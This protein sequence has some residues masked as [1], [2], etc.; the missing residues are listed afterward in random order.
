MNSTAETQAKESAETTAAAVAPALAPVPPAPAPAPEP[1]GGDG[2]GRVP[3]CLQGRI[4]RAMSSITNNKRKSNHDDAVTE[5]CQ[6]IIAED[7]APFHGRVNSWEDLEKR[8]RQWGADSD[9]LTM[10]FA[11]A[12]SR[13]WPT[14]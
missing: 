9:T 13:G 1:G 2:G 4:A 6:C 12:S 8:S 11:S 14:V 7:A 3:E 10:W 5:I